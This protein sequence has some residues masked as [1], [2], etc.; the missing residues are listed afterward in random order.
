M[1]NKFFSKK[2]RQINKNNWKASLRETSFKKTI[3]GSLNISD[4][5]ELSV[6]ILVIIKS[7]PKT[8][9][10]NLAIIGVNA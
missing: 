5:K 8:K 2:R 9:A 6:S 4:K 7:E 1:L 10:I 3:I